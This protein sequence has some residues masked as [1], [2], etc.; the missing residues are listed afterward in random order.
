MTE[1]TKRHVRKGSTLRSKLAKQIKSPHV[2]LSLAVG[3]S[4]LAVAIASKWLTPK[5]IGYLSQAFP[6]FL[7]VIYEAV[8][9]KHPDS[10]FCDIRYW[11][12]AIV[13][14]T[15]LVVALHML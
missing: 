6:P 10:K 12:V 3:T 2:Q 15:V 13:L 8:Y 14:A 5:P 1:K 7:A 4:I 9:K 11:I